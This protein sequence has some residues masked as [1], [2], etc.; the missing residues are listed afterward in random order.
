[1]CDLRGS[2]K[3]K[4]VGVKYLGF[5]KSFVGREEKA[6]ICFT[7]LSILNRYF[8]LRHDHSIVAGHSF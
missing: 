1:M 4:G 2:V 8:K 7:E 6:Y 5:H 3:V